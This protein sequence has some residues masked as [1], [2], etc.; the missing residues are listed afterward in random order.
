MADFKVKC[1]KIDFGSARG[2]YS[3]S[4]LA[5]LKGLL[6]RERRGKGKRGRKGEGRGKRMTLHTPCRKFLATPLLS[7]FTSEQVVSS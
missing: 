5:V 1:T 3:A 7:L 6:L 4:L 2:A